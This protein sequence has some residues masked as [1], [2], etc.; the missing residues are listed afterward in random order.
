VSLFRFV[1]LPGTYV[2]DHPDEFDLHGTEHDPGWDG[3]WAAF[4][5]HHN[6]RHW[7]GSKADFAAVQHGYEELRAMVEGL[8]PDRHQPPATDEPPA[9]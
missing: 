5:I 9:S 1:P 2:Y 6:N 7:W 8:W 4:H 3:D